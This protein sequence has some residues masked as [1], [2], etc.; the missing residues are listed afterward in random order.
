MGNMILAS[1]FDVIWIQFY[2]NGAAGCTARNFVNANPNYPNQPQA[3]TTVNY[4]N[5]KNTINSGASNGAKIY[6]GLLAGPVGTC[7]SP[8]DF[9]SAQ[10]AYNLIQ[11]YQGDDQFGGVMLYEATSALDSCHCGIPYFDDIKNAL[12]G[13]RPVATCSTSTSSTVASTTTMYVMVF[14]TSNSPLSWHRC[15]PPS[16]DTS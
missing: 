2:N 12:E 14:H 6:L 15:L 7:A 11:A 5:W 10:D 4:Y 13:T 3:I 9:I 8:G 16:S 1:Q